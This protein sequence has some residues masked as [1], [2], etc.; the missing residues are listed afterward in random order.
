[1]EMLQRKE[2]VGLCSPSFTFN[3]RKTANSAGSLC[4]PFTP[5]LCEG[6]L[7]AVTA[8]EQITLTVC[9]TI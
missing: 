6:K 5:I 9:S 1:M 7:N 4:A 2:V 8:T 3:S